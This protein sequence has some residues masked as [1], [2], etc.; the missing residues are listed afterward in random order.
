MTETQHY[1][2]GIEV[3]PKNADSI[4]FTIDYTTDYNLP[5]LNTDSIILT[6]E[7]RKIVLNHINSLGVFEGIPYMVKILD[8]ELDYYIDLTDAPIIGDSEIEVKIKRRK[9]VLSFMEQARGTSF[10]L[11]NKTHPIS[12]RIAQYVIIEDQQG[13]KLI[14]LAIN[15][16]TLAKELQDAIL[17]IIESAQDVI[18][19]ATVNVGVPPS[20]DLGDVIAAVALLVARIAYAVFIL[21]QLVRL[22]KQIIEILVPKVREFKC[23]TVLELITKGCQSLGYNF[24][25]TF[26]NDYKNLSILPA[27]LLN[28]DPSVFEK[29][30]ST[31]TTVY[32]KGYPSSIDTTPTLGSLINAMLDFCSGELRVIG[33]TVHLEPEFNDTP[34]AIINNTLNIQSKRENEYSFNTGDAWKRYLVKYRFDTSDLH[35]LNNYQKGQIELSTEPVTVQNQDLVSIKGLVNIDIPFAYGIRKNSLNFFETQLLKFATFADGIINGLGGNGNNAAKV[36]VR[37]GVMQISQQQFSVS[38]LLYLSGTKQPVNYLDIIGAK[39][40]QQEFHEKNQVK[41]NFKKI[42]NSSIGMSDEQFKNIVN[43]GNK[44]TDSITG[45]DLEILTIEWINQTRTAQIQYSVS[46]TEGDNTE[47]IIIFE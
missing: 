6:T 10:E 1:I 25:S 5:E 38:K 46:S 13:L 26:L 33:N 47:T 30:L 9:S 23:S 21:I 39:K 40:I 34:S 20:I 15:T 31:D 4:G 7:A 12:T 45:E 8:I 24:S 27:P 17:K 19:A 3:T 14:I 28:S 37:I 22:I 18:K 44:I 43:G 41:E 2:N 36:S 16:F 29:L 11:I 32:T 42:Q 35:T